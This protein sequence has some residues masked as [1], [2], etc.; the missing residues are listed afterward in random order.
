M[1]L[2]SY[3]LL[4]GWDACDFVSEGLCVIHYFS[5]GFYLDTI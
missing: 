5:R 4:R 2:A 1:L 3:K